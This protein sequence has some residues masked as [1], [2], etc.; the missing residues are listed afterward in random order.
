ME[1]PES[2]EGKMVKDQEK[3]TRDKSEPKTEI[4]TVS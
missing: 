4:W 3:V 1:S 2:P